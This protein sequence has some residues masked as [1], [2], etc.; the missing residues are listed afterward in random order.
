MITFMFFNIIYFIIS[1]KADFWIYFC[2][3]KVY[4]V[5]VTFCYYHILLLLS[6]E[7]ILVFSSI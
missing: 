4:F 6:P 2:V 5:I 7:F 3:L 1:Y